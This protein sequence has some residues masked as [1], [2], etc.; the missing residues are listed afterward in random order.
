MRIAVVGSG[1]SGMVSAWLLQRE[2]EVTLFEA[3]HRLG[4][5]THTVDVDL[6]SATHPVDTG[7]VVFNEGTYP[8]FI[9]LLEELGVESQPTSMSFSVR[10]Q[11]SGLEYCG[12]SLNTVFAQRRNLVRPSFYRLL[13]EITRFNRLANEATR[14]ELTNAPLRE[15]LRENH[16]HDDLARYYLLPM[17]AA[18]WS[19]TPAQIL[20]FP[21]DFLF[22]FLS[23]HR[24]LTTDG[25]Y[26]WRAVR[27]GSR[28]Y[29]R[30]MTASFSGS[31]RTGTPVQSLRRTERGVELST[32]TETEIF[33]RVIVATHSDQALRMLHE[34]TEL[35]SELLGAIEFQPND[36]QL[37][38]DKTL[39]P[40]SPRARASWNF[41]VD[42]K[43][44]GRPS[45]TYDMSRLQTLS[46][47]TPICVTL[48][49]SDRVDPNRVIESM[50]FEHPLITVKSTA[51]QRRHQEIDGQDR[52]HYCG[53]YW[54]NGFHE[55]G[56]VS[57]LTVCSHFG[58]S[59]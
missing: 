21:T 36:A 46:T 49:Q 27:G 56:V 15:F 28:E 30:A 34:P 19:S 16:F 17:A 12:T 57:A 9:R 24:L 43:T 2:H 14:S 8:N 3:S 31:I 11:S 26:P 54:G 51:A 47:Q 35:E 29:I 41:T 42:S 13:R 44:R 55:D 53:A 58:L 4:G 25:H 48:N 6:D 20:D 45:V 33:D 10:C 39:L 37:H 52:I 59:L 50:E 40:E 1:I 38:L 18:I 7:F 32:P 5:H 23:N 22:Q